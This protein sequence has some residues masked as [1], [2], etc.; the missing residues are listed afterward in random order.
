MGGLGSCS[1]SQTKTLFRPTGSLAKSF[2]SMSPAYPGTQLFL[3]WI[4]GYSGSEF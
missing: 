4:L 1:P 2:V 3:V